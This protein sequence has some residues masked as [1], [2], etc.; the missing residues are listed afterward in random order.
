MSKLV[1]DKVL[2][3][4]APTPKIAFIVTEDWFFASHFLPML[5]AARQ[6]GV[7]PVVITRVRDH[8]DL[9]EAAGARVIALEADRRS[10]NPLGLVSTVTRLARILR[11]EKIDAVHCIALRSILVGAPAAQLAGIKRRVFAV[12]GGGLLS[13]KKDLTGRFADAAIRLPIRGLFQSKE[14][15]FLFENTDDPSQFGLRPEDANVTIVGGAGVDPDHLQELP[16]PAL[17][18]LRVALVARLLWSKGVDLA[19]E[20]VRIARA[21]GHDIRLT[22][23][24]EPDP[25]NPRA[26]SPALL[27]EW[28]A[29][30]GIEWRGFVRDVRTVWQE[31]H[32]ACLPSRGG[33]GLP[34]TLLEAAACGRAIVTTDVP[35]CRHLVRDGIEGRIVPPNDA[36]A[37][38]D[39]LIQL[40][41]DHDAVAQ[42]GVAAR[43]RIH[44]GFSEADIIDAVARMY[45][46]LFSFSEPNDVHSS[47]LLGSAKS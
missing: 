35:G 4:P 30:E 32:V 45:S 1:T 24:G 11:R 15:H 34:R 29:E 8:A 46:K 37:L 3:N 47:S 7:E 25:S 28:S 36:H 43:Q 44:Q 2:Q 6:A 21:Q 19:V 39:A 17:P 26:I 14:T 38:A 13:A 20:A 5:R 41:Q 23:C 16:M 12:T 40:S 33:E 9:I 22:L 42:M 27:G 18:T 10:L 31:H